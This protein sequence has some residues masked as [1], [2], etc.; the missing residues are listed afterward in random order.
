MHDRSISAG[1]RVQPHSIIYHFTNHTSPVYHDS[2]SPRLHLSK[3]NS[4][5]L[6]SLSLLVRLPT[7]N[8]R[9][10]Q[11][12]PPSLRCPSRQLQY[13]RP[14]RHLRRPRRRRSFSGPIWPSQS[15]GMPPRVGGH[16]QWV[17]WHCAVS[18]GFVRAEILHWNSRSDIR[19][20]PS[21][22]FSILR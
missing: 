8:P 1:V 9:R 20:L 5:L 10:H 12:R 15:D 22:D 11:I 18:R 17:S 19:A 6:C 14:L 13:H 4:R 16:S 7:F 21:V 3:P 2:S